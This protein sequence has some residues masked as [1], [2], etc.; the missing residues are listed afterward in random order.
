MNKE[1][2]EGFALQT[3][4]AQVIDFRGTQMTVKVSGEVSEVT[5]SLIEMLHPPD[6]GPALHIHP[7]GAEAFYVL[8]GLYHIQCGSKTYTANPSGFVFIPTGVPHRFT[9]GSKGGKIS[10]TGDND[11]SLSDNTPLCIFVMEPV[12]LRRVTQ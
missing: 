1:T 12:K 3:D 2:K 6:V 5:C 9:S 4:E 11:P 10:S 8:E 7:T